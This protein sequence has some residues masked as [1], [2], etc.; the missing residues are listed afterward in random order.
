MMYFADRISDNIRK[1]EPEGYLICVNVPIARSGTQQ[2]LQDEIGGSGERP[3]T[4]YR[5]ED[6]VFS[7]ATM[8]SFEGMPVTNDH[9]DAEEGVTVD[10]VQYLSKGHCQNIRRGT[11]ENRDLLIGDLVIT[12]QQLIDD[13]LNG[14]REISCGYNYELHEEDGKMVQRQIRG[15]HIAVV[16]KGRAGKR[17]C[18]KDSAPNKERSKTKM[19]KPSI[20]KVL[21]RM[22]AHYAKDADPDELEQAVDA[23][24]EITSEEPAPAPAPVPEEPQQDAD[25][26]AEVMA[27]LDAIEAKLGTTDEA[28]EEDPLA[29]LEKDLDEIE[30]QNAPA[31]EEEEP[32]VPDEDPDEAEAHFVDPE[33]INEQDEDEVVEA[34]EVEEVPMEDCGP[35]KKAADA[36]RVALNAIKPVI[37]ALPPSQ[38]KKAADAAVASIRKN[39]GLSAKP[40]TNQ[41]AALKR[42][43]VKANDTAKDPADLGKAIMAKRNPQYKNK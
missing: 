19:D 7:Q 42:P 25:P 43:K 41:Y 10:N 8:A 34:E 30:A 18:I 24:E 16:D 6:E 27:R 17:V 40:K 29:R 14:K 15:N 11:G 28:P 3:V 23:V 26:M 1:R 32:M 4:V 33:A 12:D 35:S 21:A 20:R 13:I 38:R 2:Y 37:A 9:P 36:A 31:P 22:L 5:P 39:S